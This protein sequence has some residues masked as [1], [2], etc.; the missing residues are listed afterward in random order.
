MEINIQQI[1]GSKKYDFINN[2]IRCLRSV[3]S[4]IAY[5]ICH[6]HAKMKVDTQNSLPLLPSYILRKTQKTEY[7]L[8]KKQIFVQNINSTL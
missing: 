6:N 1:F 7:E 2:R 4:G 8:P 3:K 5:T